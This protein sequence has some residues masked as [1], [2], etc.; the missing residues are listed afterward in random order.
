MKNIED[1]ESENILEEKMC[2]SDKRVLFPL[3]ALNKNG[4]WRT[5]INT[6]IKKQSVLIEI[7]K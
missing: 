6:Q 2:E 7:C 3:K 4:D 1:D 5:I